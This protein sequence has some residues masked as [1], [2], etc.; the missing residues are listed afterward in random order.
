MSM[1]TV[2]ARVY[3]ARV[4]GGAQSPQMIDQADEA[5][6]RGYS[7]WQTLRNWD[8]L[9]RDN[10]LTT[11]VVGVT[12]TGASATVN[13]PSSGSF[14]FVNV[15]QGVTIGSGTATLVAGTTVSSITRNTDGTIASIVLSNAVGGTT[16]TN[17]TLTFSAYM[18]I[19]AGTNDYSLPSDCYEPYSARFITNSKRPLAYKNQRQ[20]DRTQWDQTIQGT[21]AEYTQYNPYSEATQN[22]GTQHLKFDVVP[23]QA[24]DLFLRYYRK[25]IVDGTYVDM[26]DKFLYAFLDHC[27]ARAL[28]AKR[29]QEQPTQYLA[30]V[31]DQTAKSGESEEEK[32]DDDDCYM[33]TQYEQGSNRRP[34]VGN[35]DFWPTMGS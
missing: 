8:F 18:H 26:H 14:D 19:T 5:L 21:P 23:M 31:L 12:A 22:F 20:W 6:R 30:S 28:E 32:E 25:F 1:M 15:G 29:A 13:A 35:G 4:L 3:I 17:A 7:D 34:I 9:L 33:K 11:A 2:A 24:D 27:R 16:N 10:S